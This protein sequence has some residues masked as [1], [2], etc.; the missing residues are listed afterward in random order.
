MSKFI[1]SCNDLSFLE[2]ISKGHE[3][4]KQKITC[5]DLETKFAS[6]NKEVKL[7]HQV[8]LVYM[9]S[10][11]LQFIRAVRNGDWEGHLNVLSA[12]VKYFF[13]FDKLN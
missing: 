2:V 5:T 9:V 7:M 6:F 1:D 3:I 4:V 8:I 11:M 13:A 12:F 10:L